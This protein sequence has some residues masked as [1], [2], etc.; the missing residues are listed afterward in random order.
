LDLKTK[1]GLT[2]DGE[3]ELLAGGKNLT[4]YCHDM[5]SPVPREYITLPKGE[6][7]NYSEIYGLR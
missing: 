6:Q 4:V 3:Y 1:S 5:A 2:V 7:E